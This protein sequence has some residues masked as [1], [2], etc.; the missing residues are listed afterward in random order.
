MGLEYNWTMAD[1]LVFNDS[2]VNGTAGYVS[3]F[4]VVEGMDLLVLLASVQVVLTLF[5]IGFIIL[6]LDLL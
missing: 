5:L 2:V 3:S 6:R 1:G 4:A